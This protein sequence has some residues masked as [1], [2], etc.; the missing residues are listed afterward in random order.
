MKRPSLLRLLP[1]LSPL[2]AAGRVRPPQLAASFILVGSV[3]SPI[4]RQ[5]PL[6]PVVLLTVAEHALDV[7]V[8][9]ALHADP[10]ME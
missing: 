4:S 6:S 9:G 5:L 2:G 8:Q 7:A 10:R 1:R 3:G